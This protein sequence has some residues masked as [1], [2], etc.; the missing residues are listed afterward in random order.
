MS[1]AAAKDVG[2][3]LSSTCQRSLRTFSSTLVATP[4]FQAFAQASEALNADENAR[5]ALD[6]YQTK[7]ESLRALFMLN[8]VSE[9]DQAELERLRLAVSAQPAVN[10]YLEAEK[11]LV[12][13]MQAI[14]AVISERIKL[15][16]AVSRSG[17]CS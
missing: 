14:A 6:A 1:N 7:Q 8:A 5:A 2:F 10:Q 11:T 12:A 16:F 17:C 4:Q 13:L 15:P 3:K 9:T